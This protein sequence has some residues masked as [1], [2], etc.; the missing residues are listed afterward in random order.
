[1]H[2]RG[3][4][5]THSV[6]E[7]GLQSQVL[8]TLYFSLNWGVTANNVAHPL[9]HPVS[10]DP[11]TGGGAGPGGTELRP[12]TTT[13]KSPLKPP[14]FPFCLFVLDRGPQTLLG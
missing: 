1:M 9:S 3:L 13:S 11:G 5:E 6:F 10:R 7:S 14:P 8:K 4:S 12:P 2:S